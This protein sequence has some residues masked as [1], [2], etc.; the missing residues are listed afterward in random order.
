M[1]RDQ[2][3]AQL[4]SG[5]SVDYLVKLPD[6]GNPDTWSDSTVYYLGLD[7]KRH[8]FPSAQI[9][10]TWYTDFSAVRVIDAA[11][12]AMIPLGTPVLVRPG[13]SWVK[14]QSTVETYWVEPGSYVLR[15][16]QDEA[17][18]RALGGDDWN[19][20]ILDIEPTYFTRFTVGSPIALADLSADWPE[21]ALVKSPTDA[22]IWYVTETGRRQITGTD[23][24]NANKFLSRFVET[25]NASGWQALPTETPITGFEDALFSLQH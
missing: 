19:Q 8:P 15:W 21:G 18:A 10:F 13:T 4:P 24:F 17:T 14:I 12:I 1:P 9:Y 20:N 11:T 25:N 22:L 2:A 6:D 5:Y 23:A 7:A 3:N 16:I